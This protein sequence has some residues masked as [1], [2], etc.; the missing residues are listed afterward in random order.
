MRGC[1]L[2]PLGAALLLAG[3]GNSLIPQAGQFDAAPA[4]PIK[5]AAGACNSTAALFGNG[6]HTSSLSAVIE[7]PAAAN[8]AR[9][10]CLWEMGT[11][12]TYGPPAAPIAT[13]S[14]AQQK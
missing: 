7:D 9:Q 11:R 8:P 14:I 2:A 6:A 4:N 5:Q 12:V 10:G 3:C 13:G 1:I